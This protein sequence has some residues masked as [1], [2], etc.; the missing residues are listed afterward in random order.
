MNWGTIN[1]N[2]ITIRKNKFMKSFQNLDHQLKKSSLKAVENILKNP[3]KNPT[4][5]NNLKFL[6]HEKYHRRPQMR[7]F[8][9]LI[10]KDEPQIEDICKN[11]DVDAEE[12]M[13]LL[14]QHEGVIVFIDVCTRENA[15]KKFY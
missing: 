10:E 4:L 9:C 3:K 14:S 15:E 13:E 8:Y 1:M 6:R 2:F 7:L 5:V 11:I 12:I